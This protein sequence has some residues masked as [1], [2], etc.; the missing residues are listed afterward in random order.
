MKTRPVR[1][2]ILSLVASLGLS[3]VGCRTDATE[4][5]A[6][7]PAAVTTN[8]VVAAPSS[9]ASASP[10]PPAPPAGSQAAAAPGP[11]SWTGATP[12]S[13][14]KT[15][16]TVTPVSTNAP[17]ARVAPQ[18]PELAPSV[19]EVVDM[20][21][22]SVGDAVLLEFVRNSQV[23]FEADAEDLVYLKDVGV[24]DDVVAAMLKRNAE[25]REQGLTA[26]P[27]PQ[28]PAATTTAVAEGTSA[29][30]AMGA[31]APAPSVYSQT[32]TSVAPAEP[33]PASVEPAAPP[34]TSNYFYS[35]LAPY[36]SW[37]YIEPYGWC[38]QP[39]CAV[40]VVDW[41]P[42]AHGGR[43]L[44]TTSGWYW[45]SHYSW[46]WAP[47]HY[48][49]WYASPACGWVWVPGSVWAPAWV[50][51]RYTPAYCGWAPLPPG[52]GWSTG[53][54]LTYY[55]SG[56]S[57][58][59]SFGLSSSC[60][61]FVGWDH[62]WNP[63][64]YRYCVPR[65]QHVAVYN[66]STV[67]NNYYVDNSSKTVINNG[68]PSEHVPASVRRDMRRLDLKEVPAGQRASVRPEQT[69]LDGTK[70]AVYRP[71][72][73]ADLKTDSTR[74]TATPFRTPRERSGDTKTPSGGV[75]TLPT[76]VGGAP[77]S[78]FSSPQRSSSSTSRSM[79][80]R[81]SPSSMGRSAPS[82][83]SS[84]APSPSRTSRGTP[85]PS[86]PSRTDVNTQSSPSRTSP[87]RASDSL[88]PGVPRRADAPSRG[89]PP[90]GNRI[91]R[92]PTTPAPATT[93]PGRSSSTASPS[94]T[95]PQ[96]RSGVSR[97]DPGKPLSGAAPTRSQD[98]GRPTSSGGIPT[99]SSAPPPSATPSRTVAPSSPPASL[100]RSS[101]PA[102]SRSFAP[103]TA[104]PT[105]NRSA[106]AASPPPFS[107][108]GAPSRAPMTSVPAAPGPAMQPPA[109]PSAPSG[110]PARGGG[111][112][113]AGPAPAPSRSVQ[114]Q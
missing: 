17:I 77:G 100:P 48:G 54:G 66:N 45:Q 96:S 86:A 102:S 18:M 64:P 13:A 68:V 50:T 111:T 46:G 62:C 2:P 110:V 25:L 52:C 69:S 12:V 5:S 10:V 35:T 103:N 6:S 107:A 97:G 80:A 11:E 65:A 21:Q 98:F 22:A 113:P 3:L 88:S 84:A 59:F 40:T 55:G 76:V 44:Y 31:S 56:V 27:P 28:A 26:A 57:V 78:S 92:A 60:Y 106:P 81:S 99:R 49:N 63:Y 114:P 109:S 94:A 32:V 74:T 58:G 47:F 90:T 42:Y 112:P 20:A 33:A 89:N 82:P 93:S 79:P 108:P 8:A 83:G 38:W 95:G 36:G 71:R 1:L 75:G 15:E 30:A 19:R 4:K 91:E 53:I 73:P 29:P 14:A 70:V 51:W 16:P 43:W 61:T 105:Y 72:V 41:R 87:T 104:G 39:T 23:P 24:P 85:M 7:K 101:A 9:A 67:I 34:P 37:L